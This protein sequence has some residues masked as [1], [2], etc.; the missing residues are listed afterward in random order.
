MKSRRWRVLAVLVL[1][2]VHSNAWSLEQQARWLL[3]AQATGFDAGR[4]WVDRGP[5]KLRGSGDDTEVAARVALDY[6]LYLTDTVSA[7]LA[8]DGYG[9]TESSAGITEGWLAWQ[10]IP[11]SPW[12]FSA[13]AGSVIPPFSMEN[14][15]TGWTSPYMLTASVQNSW[16]GEELRTNAV[17]FTMQRRGSLARSAHT[18]TLKAAAFYG[19]DTSGTLL[20]W[21]GWA[22]NDRVTPLGDSLPLPERAALQAGG[23]FPG[24][25]RT[26]PFLEIDDAPGYYATAEWRYRN[27]VEVSL[28]HYDNRADPLVFG[29]GQ[30]GWRTKF[31]V[32]GLRWRA[33]PDTQV[34]AQYMG[35]DTLVGL[36]GG[37]RSA[38]NEFK[39]W[40]VL[41]VR[42]WRR[43][44]FAARY[45][46]FEVRDLDYTPLDD[47][48]ETGYAWALSWQLEWRDGLTLGTELL[49]ID[50]D[51]PELAQA[52]RDTSVSED[53]VRFSVRYR[54]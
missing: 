49:R 34:I 22:A 31:N 8:L 21:R 32:A 28:G 53:Q 6:A 47:N 50:Y 54:F 41:A 46:R 16:I 5:G 38:D 3:E 1:L 13:R 45:E 52:G 12:A 17:E 33:A 40:Y 20:S 9:G 7:H 25:D 26:D 37:A 4:S 29:N 14:I 36:R 35:G 51:R 30:A 27:V 10:P 48:R 15:D 44:R 24:A 18:I 23:P 42:D 19:N 43:H 2:A 11:S 39:S